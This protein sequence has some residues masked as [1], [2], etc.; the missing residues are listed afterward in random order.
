[1]RTLVLAL[2]LLGTSAEIS[3]AATLSYGVEIQ[4]PV[5]ISGGTLR[6]KTVPF[7]DSSLGKLKSISHS[8]T[9][10][11]ILDAA[12]DE[13]SMTEGVIFGYGGFEVSIGAEPHFAALNVV[14]GP[15]EFSQEIRPGEIGSYHQEGHF[16]VSAFVDDP[17]QI[18]DFIGV[19]T[20]DMQAL[21]NFSMY[22]ELLTN[23]GTPITPSGSATYSTILT[24]T[25]DSAVPEVATWA[26]MIAGF[27]LVGSTIRLRR[28]RPVPL[29][30]SIYS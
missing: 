11:F 17:D 1:M 5:T 22:F 30:S 14:A 28:F 8:G 9:I 13:T 3:E 23:T 19:G 27:G 20:F 16:D 6:T 7:F 2:A 10:D 21:T 24:Y 18:D 4:A 25:Y 29:G 15:V 26:L 12:W